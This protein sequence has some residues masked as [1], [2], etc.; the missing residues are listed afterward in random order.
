[1]LG[2]ATGHG[3]A[4]GYQ[5]SQSSAGF[6]CDTYLR[7]TVAPIYKISAETDTPQSL[8]PRLLFRPE[9]NLVSF[10]TF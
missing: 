5:T 6:Y 2:G 8:A 1:M 7:R 9:T 10:N 4:A 3:Q